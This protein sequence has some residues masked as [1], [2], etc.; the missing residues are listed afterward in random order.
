MEGQIHNVTSTT[1]QAEIC[2]SVASINY[3]SSF[4]LIKKILTKTVYFKDRNEKFMI[5]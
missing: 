5:Q 1:F 2:C 4:D 3:A